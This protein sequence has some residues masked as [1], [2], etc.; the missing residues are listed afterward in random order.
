MIYDQLANSLSRNQETYGGLNE[1][2]STGKKINKPSDDVFGMMRA[3]DYRVSINSNDQFQRNIDEGSLRLNLTDTTMK[4][5]SDTLASVR[6]LIAFSASGVSDPI[7]QSTYSTN[8]VQ[9]RDN[10][11]SFANARGAGQYLFSGYRMDVQPYTDPVPVP[12]P[13]AYT[14]QG[15][16]GVM[17]V[18]I[19]QSQVMPINITGNEAFSYTLGAPGTTEVK[20]ISNGMMVHYTQGAG[21]TINVEIR[22]ADDVQRLPGHPP[23]GFPD[24]DTFS[25]SNVLQMTDVLSSAISTNNIS[26]INALVSP[27]DKM[28][29][30]AMTVQAEIGS[31]LSQL[32]AQSDR[33]KNVTNTLQNS[34]SVVEDAD[35]TQTAVELNKTDVTLQALRASAARI[36]SQSLLDFLK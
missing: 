34:L 6:Q 28:S 23:D 14:Y 8:A 18:Q 4:S 29:T 27:F 17:N 31:R 32:N 24:D 5:V 1:R 11:L 30:Q 10:L 33:L 15:D 22:Q 19:D 20:Q 13:A 21:T 2:L 36:L 16:T 12:P 7:L 3:M 9:L 25:F 26:R 35:M